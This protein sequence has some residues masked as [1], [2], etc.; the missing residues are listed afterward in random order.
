M[1]TL[2]PRYYEIPQCNIMLVYMVEGLLLGRYKQ[3]KRLAGFITAVCI[4]I[5]DYTE[6]TQV[7]YCIII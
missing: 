6:Y 2:V 3:F 4:P 7:L 1:F 5:Y